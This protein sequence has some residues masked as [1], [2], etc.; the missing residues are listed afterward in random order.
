MSSRIPACRWRSHLRGRLN[1]DEIIEINCESRQVVRYGVDIVRGQRA[2]STP[3]KG[4]PWGSWVGGVLLDRQ[5]LGRWSLASLGTGPAPSL[6]PCPFYHPL[7][8]TVVT[9]WTCTH[10]SEKSP[11]ETLRHSRRPAAQALCSSLCPSRLIIRAPV[12]NRPPGG[13]VMSL[14]VYCFLSS[15]PHKSAFKWK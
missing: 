9:N 2:L 3:C 1:Y 5:G 6:H 14:H 12:P 7:A 8:S 13:C 15:L 11:A 10:S 4:F